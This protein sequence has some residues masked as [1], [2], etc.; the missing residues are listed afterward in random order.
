MSLPS[1]EEQ[2]RFRFM[3]LAQVGWT[4]ATPLIIGVLLDWWLG[5]MPW[6]TV[7]GALLGPVVGFV[8]MLNILRNK[9]TKD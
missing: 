7:I 5:T 2:K 4:I 6:C 3:Q 1:S 8:Q 9:E